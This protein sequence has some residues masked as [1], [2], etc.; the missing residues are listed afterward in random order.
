MRMQ[1]IGA[2]GMQFQEA[3]S[4]A[5]LNQQVTGQLLSRNKAKL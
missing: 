1:P 2:F 4:L 5:I 3:N